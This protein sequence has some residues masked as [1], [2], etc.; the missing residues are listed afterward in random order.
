MEILAVI[1]AR[2]GSKGI[3]RKNLVNLAG[4][5]LIYYSI[6]VALESSQVTRT[7]VSTEDKE[8]AKIAKQFGAEIPFLRPAKYAA[9]E[10]PDI[11]V[12]Q[13]ALLFLK[14]KEHYLPDFVVYLRPT[15]PIRKVETVDQSI[16]VFKTSSRATS[17]RSVSIA[18]QTPYKM[19]KIEDEK[20]M[21][22]LLKL[23]G[24]PEPYNTPRQKLPLVYWQNG[25]IDI[26]LYEQIVVH[27]SMM[28]NHIMPFIIKEEVFD[29]DSMDALK[30]AEEYIR[31]GGIKRVSQNSSI[32]YPG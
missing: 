21:M 17:L 30:K 13:H 16:R 11:D 23:A 25:Y 29:I 15:C 1:P 4:Y 7:V 5:P 3:S 28:G 32:E 12:L 19:W 18:K 26:T 14:E 24:N 2:G 10:S 20:T 22:P 8:I 27:S 6:K 9:D 31:S